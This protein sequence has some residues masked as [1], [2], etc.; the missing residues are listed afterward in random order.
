MFFHYFIAN[1]IL[2]QKIMQPHDNEGPSLFYL[3]FPSL[4]NLFVVQPISLTQHFIIHRLLIT[5]AFQTS[6]NGSCHLQISLQLMFIMFK[7][8]HNLL[9][10][11]GFHP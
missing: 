8:A 1:N 7:W 6:R 5:F 2:K 4:Q 10:Y 11:K 3:S 9:C